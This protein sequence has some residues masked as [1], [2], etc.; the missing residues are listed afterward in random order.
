VVKF[1]FT[2]NPDSDGDGI[3]NDVD[4]K[5]DLASVDFSDELLPRIEIT[6]GRIQSFDPGVIVEVMDAPDF[7]DGVQIILSG[8]VGGTAKV[9]I[10]SI[11]GAPIELTSPGT[12]I[13]TNGSLI[14]EVI[15]GSARIEFQIGEAL[16]VI[17]I[18]GKAIIYEIIEA[19][20]LQEISV[21]SVAGSV[22]VNDMI[23]SPGESFV[24]FL[25][26]SI[27]VK[28]GNSQNTINLGSNGVTPTA[29]LS[30]DNFDATTIDPATIKLSGAPVK[31]VGKVPQFLCSQDDVNHDGLSDLLCNILT[32]E[33]TVDLEDPIAS[34]E[35]ERYDGTRILGEDDLNIVP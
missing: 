27:D 31:Q 26:V 35:A 32:A 30:S 7:A 16:I 28:P 15:E 17:L 5:P 3:Y 1:Q 22:Q 19:G 4:E 6:S 12:Y 34:L 20:V 9:R 13:F 25:G 23:V 29:I 21:V 33:M 10:D 18:E 24:A 11:K 14:A 2:P 8:L